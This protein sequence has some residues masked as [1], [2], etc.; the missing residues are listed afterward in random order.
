[1]SILIPC[2]GTL[3]CC[4]G[5]SDD[6]L[7]LG[8]PVP[9]TAAVWRRSPLRNDGTRKEVCSPIDRVKFQ[10][11]LRVFKSSATVIHRKEE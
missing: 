10:G 6:V 1:M 4:R 3:Q 11:L 5:A 9:R 8:Q 2:L 7:L